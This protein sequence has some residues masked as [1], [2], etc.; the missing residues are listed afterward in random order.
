MMGRTVL[1]TANGPEE[2]TGIPLEPEMIVV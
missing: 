1:I 2:I